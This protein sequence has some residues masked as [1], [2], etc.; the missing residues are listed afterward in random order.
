MIMKSTLSVIRHAILS[1]L[2]ASAMYAFRDSEFSTFMKAFPTISETVSS[3]S[4][5][6]LFPH[7]LDFRVAQNLRI[8]EFGRV[9]ESEENR[10]NLARFRKIQ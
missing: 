4:T 1:S 2:G 7:E 9:S 3:G 10:T 6:A 5:S 8:C